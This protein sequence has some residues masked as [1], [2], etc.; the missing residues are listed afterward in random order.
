MLEIILVIAIVAVVAA[1]AVRSFYRTMT[2]KNNG[3]A[4]ICAGCAYGDKRGVLYS[5]GMGD[6]ANDQCCAPDTIK[7][8]PGSRD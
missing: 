5:V 8:A 6:N 7:P 2:G 3:C 1:L 4:G